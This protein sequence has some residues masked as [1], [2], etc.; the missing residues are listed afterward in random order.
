MCERVL[1]CYAR[2]QRQHRIRLDD[3][4][5]PVAGQDQTQGFL[6]PMV[7]AAALIQIHGE[8]RVVRV[9]ACKRHEV[10]GGFVAAVKRFVVRGNKGY[11]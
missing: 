7:G 6:S 2:R 9:E 10:R 3:D 4:R 8:G 5:S 11:Q 1:S